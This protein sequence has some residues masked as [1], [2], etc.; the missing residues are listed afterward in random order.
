MGQLY[1]SVKL[2]NITEEEVETMLRVRGNVQQNHVSGH[3]IAI[4][5]MNSLQLWLSTKDLHKIG[6]ANT[7][8]HG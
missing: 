8:Y 5:L 4:A 3:Y 6:L 2:R 7:F 1:H